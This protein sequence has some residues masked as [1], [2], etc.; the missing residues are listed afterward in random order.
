[1]RARVISTVVIFPLLVTLCFVPLASGK[2]T[3]TVGA[4]VEGTIFVTDSEGKQSFVPGATVKLTGPVTCETQTDE[5]GRYALEAVPFGTY[6]LEAVSPGL[7]AVATISV[8]TNQ[9]QADLELKPTAVTDSVVVAA[10]QEASANSTPSETIAAKTLR[11]APN[12][13]E[14]FESS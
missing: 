10:D 1:M 2:Q 5:N 12:V 6:E 13:N 9:V 11:E 14:R 7:K 8:Q 3:D 4:K